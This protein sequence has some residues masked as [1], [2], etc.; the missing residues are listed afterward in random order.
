MCMGLESEIEAALRLLLFERDRAVIFY[1]RWLHRRI[2]KEEYLTIDD[3]RHT[4]YLTFIL[5]N[6]Y[7]AL[8]HLK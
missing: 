3:N 7:P 4:Q 5:R 1:S 2:A 8:T 6:H